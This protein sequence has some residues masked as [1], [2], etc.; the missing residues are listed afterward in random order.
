[1]MLRDGRKSCT[2]SHKKISS[3]SSRILAR[4]PSYGGISV[5]QSVKSIKLKSQENSPEHPVK[6]SLTETVEFQNK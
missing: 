5:H 2:N 1:M 6:M 4:N 3:N